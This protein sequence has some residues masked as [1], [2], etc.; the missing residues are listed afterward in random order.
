VNLVERRQRKSKGRRGVR[1]REWILCFGEVVA[2]R[3]LTL[4]TNN[5]FL[6]RCL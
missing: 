6:H 4:V 3:V 1:E 5:F 2:E